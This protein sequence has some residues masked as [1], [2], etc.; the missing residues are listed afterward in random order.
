M[1]GH[2]YLLIIGFFLGFGIIAYSA[3]ANPTYTAAFNNGI[4]YLVTSPNEVWNATDIAA[5]S[6][7]SK[8]FPI[9]LTGLSQT[10]DQ[11]KTFSSEQYP[12]TYNLL[13]A[14]TVAPSEFE[15]KFETIYFMKKIYSC[16]DLTLQDYLTLSQKKNTIIKPYEAT[17]AV[18]FL[19]YIKKNYSINCLKPNQSNLASQNLP[20]ALNGL[21]LTQTKEQFDAWVEQECARGIGTGIIQLNVITEILSKQDISGGWFAQ[22]VQVNPDWIDE[23]NE[24]KLV[25][26][27]YPNAHTSVFALC[28]LGTSLGYH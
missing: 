24:N 22:G 28:I 5:Y 8:H 20:L 1:I 4:N 3:V 21:G 17:H 7:V 14:S 2:K 25:K 18:L 6:I 11:K 23:L 12:F 19:S 16:E 15:S 26:G 13:V 27:E 9:A 10:I